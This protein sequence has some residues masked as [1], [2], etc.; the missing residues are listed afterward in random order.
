MTA[1]SSG[2]K[3]LKYKHGVLI[4]KHLNWSSQLVLF[5]SIELPRCLQVNVFRIKAFGAFI[6]SCCSRKT[7]KNFSLMF[8][9]VFQY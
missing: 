2:D 1:I 7:V 3:I 8:N 5:K 4:C 9:T 6:E